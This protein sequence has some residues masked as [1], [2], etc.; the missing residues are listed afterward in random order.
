MTIDE[1]L[2]SNKNS[3]ELDRDYIL[4]VEYNDNIDYIFKTDYGE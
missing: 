4:K 1:F 2:T 3:C